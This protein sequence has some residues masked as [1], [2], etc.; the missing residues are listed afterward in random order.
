MSPQLSIPGL[1]VRANV[2]VGGVTIYGTPGCGW[3]S[4]QIEDFKRKHIQFDFV[5][6]NKETCPTIVK[7]FPTVTGYPGETDSWVGY[8]KI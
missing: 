6:C 3:T 4:K 8:K 2:R 5:D 1:R 7:A